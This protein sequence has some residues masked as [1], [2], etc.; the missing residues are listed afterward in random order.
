M[1]D[2]EESTTAK[3]R[4]GEPR[5]TT[6]PKNSSNEDDGM[7]EFEDPFEDELEQ[8]DE[9]D[10]DEMEADDAE[11]G[12]GSKVEV[13]DDD[14]GGGDGGARQGAGGPEIFRRRVEGVEME[15]DP[16]AYGMLHRMRFE[17]PALSFD[18]FR[19]DLGA[20]RW[21]YPHS[22][23][24]VQG[25][26]GADRNSLV[27]MRA[28]HLARTKRTAE[29]EENEAMGVVADDDDANEDV[30]PTMEHRS[31]AHDGG[32][33]RVRANH[34][35][36]GIV[37]AWSD[38]GAVNI[39]DVGRALESLGHGTARGVFPSANNAAGGA[40]VHTFSG[41]KDEGYALDWSRVRA[42]RMASGD[43][44]GR[45]H[46]WDVD[47]SG[48]VAVDPKPFSGH[49]GSLEDLQWSPTEESVVASCGVDKT[50]RIWDIRAP[51][52][53]GSMLSVRAHEADVNVISWNHKVA[54]LLA[55]GSDDASFKVWDLR[56]FKP[57]EPIGWFKGFHTEPITSIEWSPHDESV[58]VCSSEDE[59]VSVW[60]L[61]LEDDQEVAASSAA[62]ATTTAS[63]G[64]VAAVDETGRRVEIPPQ[65]LFAHAGL[66]DPKEARF[67]PHIVG[68]VGATAADGFDLFIS[69]P[70]ERVS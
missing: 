60:D 28:S 35:V 34:V 59:Q 12:D 50:V 3:R 44:T 13:D 22:V 40:V 62:A 58:L 47:A 20:E 17:W 56:N 37:A 2:V 4:P 32:V 10:E 53:N 64:P 38:K 51:Q 14:E 9:L 21:R 55:S 26:S 24:L 30:D 19:D 52:R 25:S 67:H 31:F 70:L 29:D 5:A 8:E 48:R 61:A 16:S 65:L 1:E 43:C 18:F 11:E 7:G 36:P 15:H 49:D 6:A 42:T 46:V 57:S 54:F 68:L 33:N 69:E 27:V 63:A 23:W 45:F 39:Y 66:S 41:H